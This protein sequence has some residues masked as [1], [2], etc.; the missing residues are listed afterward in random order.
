MN[1]KLTLVVC[2]LVALAG[3]AA[4]FLGFGDIVFDPTN[5]AEAIEQVLESL[6]H[7]PT[8]EEAAKR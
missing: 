1:R 2:L 4:A 3:K 6:Q 5:Y 8:I 7:C